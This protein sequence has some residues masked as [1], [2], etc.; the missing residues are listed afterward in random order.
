MEKEKILDSGRCIAFY[1][2][3]AWRGLGWLWSMRPR[4]ARVLRGRRKRENPVLEN[5]KNFRK[6]WERDRA[7]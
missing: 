7:A 6:E 3:L 2:L 4:L 1:L 5:L